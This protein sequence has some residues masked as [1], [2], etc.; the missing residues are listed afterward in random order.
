MP[1][2]DIKVALVYP[3]HQS[4]PGAQVKPN[5]SLAYPSLAG[6]L[7][8]KGIEVTVFDATVGND[9]DDLADMF[10]VTTPLD[11]GLLRTG[12]SEERI[13][14]EVADC[15]VVG[16]TSIFSEQETM[17]LACAR[18]VKKH[19]PEKLVVSG[20]VNARNRL[21]QFFA[22]GVDLVCLSEA[23]GT[24]IRIVEVLAQGGR[25]FSAI[26]SVAFHNGESIV[27]NRTRPEDVV[28]NLDDL[29]MPAWHLLPNQR[30][31]DIGRPHGGFSI[32]GYGKG[33]LRYASMQTSMG[34]PFACQFCHVAGETEGS[35]SGDVGRFR[36]KS[37]ERVL[38]EIAE[39]EKLGVRQ[40]YIEDDSLFGRRNRG[41]NL[42]RKIK[43]RGL[44]ILD[45]NGVNVIH[46][47]RRNKPDREIIEALAEAGF[48][49][50]ALP[51]ESGNKR[52][53][54]KYVSKKWD[55]ENSDIAGLIALC[56]EYGLLTSGS[57][58]L[59]Y[60]D[61]T[62]EEIQNTIE[63]AR[64]HVAS[65]LD[66]AHFMCILPLP[67]TPLFDMAI[68]NGNLPL[69]FN[70]D[71]MHWM[72]A[73]LINTPVPPEELEE[74]RNRAW[75]DINPS[76]FKEARRAWVAAEQRKTTVR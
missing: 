24:I 27:V 58:I 50:I 9:K 52:I 37:D 74:I 57:Y 68:R 60:P 62:R 2:K 10:Y 8:A 46:L 28:V 49:E 40:I 38:A 45:V 54:E 41:L 13:L 61:E 63:L 42:L 14:E 48:K 3:P 59:G 64:S 29:P 17:V 21:P 33:E 35:I 69:D 75:E 36:I 32:A 34:C 18:L 72:R 67:G 73:N 16:L 12:V 19:F 53:I 70:I 44:E 71:R 15:D 7:L 26:S 31:W 65:G 56:K 1:A 6:A 4:W 30:Y 22:A 55:V 25:D 5:G 11:S 76:G 23:E 20:G 66:S 47:L 39:L 43:G 51:F